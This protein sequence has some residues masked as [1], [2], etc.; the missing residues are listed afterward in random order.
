M[1]RLYLDLFLTTIGRSKTKIFF[2]FMRPAVVRRSS[3]FIYL[4][5]FFLL[6]LLLPFCVCV[7]RFDPLSFRFKKVSK[8]HP[9]ISIHT[10]HYP[11]KY[12]LGLNLLSL[13]LLN[14]SEKE[15]KKWLCCCCLYP[16]FF[17]VEKNKTRKKKKI[18]VVDLCIHTHIYMYVSSSWGLEE[19]DD[20]AKEM[21]IKNKKKSLGTTTVG[22]WSLSF[23]FAINYL[24]TE[25]Y[26]FGRVCRPRSCVVIL[27]FIF[28]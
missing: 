11:A 8:F 27:F 12:P 7:F 3:S 4:R 13:T 18:Y 16:F 23:F 15:K 20:G 1:T 22:C 2:L 9:S 6:L 14:I 25:P 5:E 21:P 28:V 10:T 24:Q 26:V 19:K 17:F